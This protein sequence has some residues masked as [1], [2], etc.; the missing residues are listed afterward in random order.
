ML[1]R[2]LFDKL[3]EKGKMERG[4]IQGMH[5]SWGSGIATLMISGRPVHCDNGATVRALDA[6]FGDVI[7]DGHCFDV[8]KIVGKEIYYSMDDMGLILE[9]FTP[10]D[11]PQLDEEIDNKKAKAMIRGLG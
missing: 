3:V 2:E 11:D 6:A 5:G 1:K 8:S 7:T 9:C 4:V 10:A